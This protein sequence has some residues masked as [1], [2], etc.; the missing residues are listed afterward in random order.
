MGTSSTLEPSKYPTPAI[1]TE[2]APETC[3]D[4]V[5]AVP[6][7]MVE[8]LAT[9]DAITGAGMSRMVYAAVASTLAAKFPPA[10]MA[11]S[12]PD[13]WKVTVATWREAVVGALPSVVE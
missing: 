9:N 13:A 8:G 11:R 5:T 4:S 1:P 12:T 2:V 7:T 6:G 10:Q 3:H